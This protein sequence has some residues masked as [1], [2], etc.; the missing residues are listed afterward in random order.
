MRSPTLRALGLLSFLLALLVLSGG[1]PV[2]LQAKAPSASPAV[3]SQRHHTAPVSVP[4]VAGDPAWQQ[5]AGSGPP[6]RQYATMAYDASNQTAVL[7]DG[8]CDKTGN[9]LVDTWIWN[10]TAWAAS[11]SPLNPPAREHAAMAYDPATQQIVLFGGCCDSSGN[12]LGDTWVWNGSAWSQP[13]GVTSANSPSP[14]QGAAMAFDGSELVLFGGC[15]GSGGALADTWIW[16]GTGWSQK[17][18]SGPPA[19]ELASLAYDGAHTVLFG[20][21]NGSTTLGDTWTWDGS[22]W[23]QQCGSCVAGTSEPSARDLAGMAQVSGGALLFGGC[24]DIGGVNLG[25]AWLW[26]TAAW[27]K[28]SVSGGPSARAGLSLA[29]APGNATLL[30]GGCC[31]ASG[32]ALADTWVL[33]TPPTVTGITPA[34][35][36]PAGGTAVTIT[37]TGF[38]TNAGSTAIDFGALAATKVSCS[39]ST[40][41]SATSPAGLDTVDVT[42]TVAGLTSATSSADLFTYGTAPAAAAAVSCTGTGPSGVALATQLP[43]FTNPSPPTETDTCN[44]SLTQALPAGESVQVTNTAP[45]IQS[46]TATAVDVIGGPSISSISPATTNGS[47]VGTGLSGPATHFDFSSPAATLAGNAIPVVV[48][49]LDASN[50]IVTGY[51]GTVQ[52]SSSDS[53]A[54][55]LPQSYTFTSCPSGCDNGSHTFT[56]TFNTPGSQSISA[57]DTQQVTVRGIGSPIEVDPNPTGGPATHLTVVAPSGAQAGSSFTVVVTAL[58][59]SD[60][61]A[62][63]YTGTVSLSSTDSAAAFSPSSYTFT[64]S[65]SS[66]TSSCDNGSHPFTVTLNTSTQPP[67][68]NQLGQTITVTDTTTKGINGSSGRISVETGAGNAASHLAISVP[69]GATA[70]SPFSVIVTALDAPNSSTNYPGNNLATGFTDQISITSSDGSAGLPS[71]YTFS[72][73]DKGTHRFGVTLNALGSSVITVTDVSNG[74]V[75]FSKEPVS[76]TGGSAGPATKLVVSMP[77]GATAGASAPLFVTALDKNGHLATSFY[78][79][80]QFSSTDANATLPSIFAS[81]TYWF[82]STGQLSAPFTPPNPATL[83]TTGCDNGWHEFSGANGVTF[84]TSYDQVLDSDGVGGGCQAA[85][86]FNAAAGAVGAPNAPSNPPSNTCAFTN[87]SGGTLPPGTPAGMAT[88]DDG[89]AFVATAASEMAAVCNATGAGAFG[90]AQCGSSSNQVTATAPIA[91]TGPGN[92]IVSVPVVTSV[93]PTSGPVTGQTNVTVSG[94]GFDPHATTV[95]F[96]GAA[97]TINGNCGATSCNVTSPQSPL[98]APGDGQVDVQVTTSGGTSAINANDTFNYRPVVTSISP[99]IGVTG[100]PVTV[101]GAGF[102]T[103]SGNTTVKFGGLASTPVTCASTTQCTAPAAILPLGFSG[104]RDVTVT[105]N[106]ETSVTSPSDQF[107]YT[108]ASPAAATCSGVFVFGGSVTCTIVT[109]SGVPAPGSVSSTETSLQIT[110]YP[111]NIFSSGGLVVQTCTS[112]VTGIATTIGEDSGYD[113]GSANT[114]AFHTTNGSVSVA[115]GAII[116]TMTINVPSSLI[117]ITLT[118]LSMQGAVCSQGAESFGPPQCGAVG[119]QYV[120]SAPIPVAGAGATFQPTPT[121][122][123]VQAIG[124]SAPGSFVIVTGTNFG[125]TQ[126]THFDFGPGNPSP[127]VAN[128]SCNSGTCTASAVLVPS[129]PNPFPSGGVVDVQA[130]VNGVSSAVNSPADQFTYPSPPTVTAINPTSGPALGGTTVTLTG[131]GFGALGSGTTLVNFGPFQRGASCSSSTSCTVVSPPGGGTQTVFVTVNGEISDQK[132]GPQFTYTPSTA[133]ASWNSLAAGGPPPRSGASLASNGGNALLFGGCSDVACSSPLNDTW[134]WNGNAWAAQNPSASPPAR[135][136]ASLSAAPTPGSMLLFGGRD[137][138]GTTLSDTWVWNGA[139]SQ[140]PNVTQGNSPPARYDA[141][142]AFDPVVNEVVLF[143]GIGLNG[144]ALGDAWLWNGKSWQGLC[145]T[146]STSDCPLTARSSP[147]MAFNAV[148]NGIVLFGGTGSAGPLADTWTLVLS[149]SSNTWTAVCGADSKP[150]CGPQARSL[151]GMGYDQTHETDVLFGGRSSSGTPL[152]D[153]WTFDG[154]AW[155]AACGTGTQPACA[156]AARFGAAMASMDGNATVLLFGG[157]GGGHLLGDTDVWGPVVLPSVSKLSPASGSA[158]GGTKVTITGTGFSA[159]SG[160]TAVDFGTAA[161]TNVSCSSTTQC[162]AVSPAAP[163]GAAGPVDVTISVNGSVSKTGSSDTFTYTSGLGQTGSSVTASPT[164]VPDNGTATSTVTV[165]LLD[166]NGQALVNQ[167]VSLAGNSGTHSVIT[168]AGAATPSAAALPNLAT[169]PPATAQTNASGIATFTVADGT[170]ESVTYTAKVGGTPLSTPATV[171][172]IDVNTVDP[173]ASTMAATYP[174]APDNGT[175]AVTMTV[176][177]K[178]LGGTAA[179]NQTVKLAGNSGTNSSIN[180]TGGSG[181]TGTTDSNGNVSFTVTD[182]HH[183]TVT[184]TATDTSVSP[185]VPVTQTQAVAFDPQGDANLDG[186]V[187]AVDALCILRKV[188]GLAATTTCTQTPAT[189]SADDVNRNGTVDSVD[190]LCTLRIVAN[191][192]STGGCQLFPQVATPSVAAAAPAAA[193]SPTMTAAGSTTLTL[194]ASSIPLQGHRQTPVSVDATTAGLGLGSWTVDVHYD[195][196]SVRVVSC[197]SATGSLCNTSYKPGVIR[198]VGASAAGLT[199]KQ[200][201]ATITFAGAGGKHGN[202]SLTLAPVTLASPNG[203]PLKIAGGTAAV[204]PAGSPAEQAR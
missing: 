64:S 153:T 114:C 193:A 40:T 91:V 59:A 116:G 144:Q 166:S 95:T 46:V 155:T 102:D 122:T 127:Q 106:G 108:T 61:V 12:A 185:A 154:T 66:C 182:S 117:G 76:V 170:A 50:N 138:N 5:I 201:L 113:N 148:T 184:Y 140:P 8:C 72:S 143:G 60:G 183:E 196:S 37:G 186:S 139:W 128:I 58:N 194:S 42:V 11:A 162:V 19:R 27:S 156:P 147:S 203:V 181:A 10:G 20:G 41:C 84:K 118:G 198:I 125:T 169:T 142:M 81:K 87:T 97:A 146:A 204:G 56:V 129:P 120:P 167:T 82:T 151:A 98:A 124:A 107:T 44:V 35:G 16:N 99:Q 189:L 88:F 130:V 188:A 15:C 53:L 80:V 132:N 36:P 34:S 22:V 112:S 73:A 179:S 67:A 14:R 178:T 133:P 160:G 157:N 62:T 93:N 168:P 33:G 176:T 51:T 77:A 171:N 38:N 195:P 119:N 71:N 21:Q 78:G 101:S 103:I 54:S 32:D 131:A 158:S 121:V 57:V 187:T 75:S 7:V 145:G 164:T 29:A 136:A 94:T 163:G 26:N 55:G 110:A 137:A 135:S 30:F 96:G 52:L 180:V 49:V 6:A 200:T 123:K 115:K 65:S 192:A 90:T 174:A 197:A 149:G 165:T 173:A 18:V 109:T 25:D 68:S 70:G 111:T 126:N 172:F 69:A 28:M 89:S 199:G 63:G 47:T 134:T 83:C 150:A 39:S 85:T 191:L 13:A 23:T 2:M 43:S 175:F 92:A 104:T 48:T 31:D 161:S 105:V 190:A 159:A 152:A 17:A 100:T 79:P 1:S 4:A 45:A 177:L 86:N 202:S 141:G 3:H 74:N 9:K 24:C